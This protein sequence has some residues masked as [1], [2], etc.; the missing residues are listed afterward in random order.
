MR[1]QAF[2]VHRDEHF[3][4]VE[5]IVMGNRVRAPEQVCYLIRDSQTRWLAEQKLLS[6][7]HA[8]D[9]TDSGI[10]VVNLEG[11]VTYANRT[12]ISLLAGGDEKAVLGEKL[13]VW[14]D[15]R[16]VVEPLFANMMRRLPWSA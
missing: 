10:G 6:A 14:F 15:P 16:N 5:I 13:S 9:N 2:A 11:R 4:A 3:I 8:M 1:I 12:M 7:Y